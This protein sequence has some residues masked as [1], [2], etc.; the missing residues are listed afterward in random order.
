MRIDVCVIYEWWEVGGSEGSG[1]GG[2]GTMVQS[3]T[4]S[5]QTAKAIN[6]TVAN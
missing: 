5:N 3:P 6:S 2:A 4:P 1:N